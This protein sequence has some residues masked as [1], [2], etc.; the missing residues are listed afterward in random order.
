MLDLVIVGAGPYG[1]SLAANASAQQLSY[2]MFGQPMSFWKEDM[3]QNMYIRTPCQFV[4]FSDYESR[5]TMERFAEETDAV[6]DYPLPRSSFI[7]YASWFM[8]KNEVTYIPEKVK[9]IRGSEYCFEV[10]LMTGETYMTRNVVIAT[11]ISDFKYI[12]EVLRGQ[13]GTYV[14]HS[15]GYTSFSAFINKSVIV[16]GSGQ[17]AWEAAVLL[18]EAEVDVEIIYRRM[19]PNYSVNRM[20]D[21]RLQTLGNQFYGLSPLVKQRIRDS[22]MSSAPVA[23]FLQPLVEGKVRQTGNVTIE[24]TETSSDKIILTL[25]DGTRRI[26]DHVIAAT[27]FMMNVNNLPMLSIQLKREI[28]REQGDVRY[29]R[30]NGS[31]E[32]SVRGLYF[33]GP[34]TAYSHGPT[35]LFLLG[36]R[37]TARSITQAI[38]AHKGTGG[39]Y[40]NFKDITE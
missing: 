25:S 39:R 34:L 32:T 10:E 23:A 29:P 2:R 3:P 33:A 7:Q 30:L 38:V 22:E 27:G 11:G 12:P 37:K 14:S 13:F 24:K 31:F 19:L 20:D 6:L 8:K 18:R 17:S 35:F 5:Y 4:S 21:F 1:I 40:T 9:K 16:L 36:L 15:S 28:Q 26:A